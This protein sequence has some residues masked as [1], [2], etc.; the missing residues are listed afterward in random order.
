MISNY[1]SAMK[2]IMA[3]DETWDHA[4]NLE[5]TNQSSK[6]DNAPSNTG[7][8]LRDHFVENSTRISPQPLY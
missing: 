7:L 4:Y 3:G 1:Q 6:F 8:V 5:T 2:R